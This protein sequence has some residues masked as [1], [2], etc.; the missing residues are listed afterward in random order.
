MQKLHMAGYQKN[1]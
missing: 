1:Q